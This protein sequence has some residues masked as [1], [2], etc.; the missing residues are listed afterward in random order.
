MVTA[1]VGFQCPECAHQ[2]AASQRLVDV[3]RR[4]TVPYV[5]YVLIGINVAVFLIGAAVA[6]RLT[7]GGVEGAFV[8]RYAVFTPC[9]GAGQWYRLVTGGF[10]HAGLLHLGMNMWALWVLGRPLEATLGRARFLLI[11]AVSL[12]GGAAGVVI[13]DRLG[14]P[15]LTVGA[16]GAIF[17]LL[18]ALVVLQRSRG[19]GFAQSGLAGVIGLNLLITFAIPGISIGGHLGGLVAGS[20]CAFVMLAP[21][22]QRVPRWATYATPAAVGIV[23]VVASVLLVNAA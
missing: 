1:S 18:G 11:Y 23:S 4:A 8:G 22:Y 19:I 12:L 2:G 17:G 16:S 9:V 10:L 13:V 3:H 15:S 21:D 20:L 6:A 14:G 5:T 7:T